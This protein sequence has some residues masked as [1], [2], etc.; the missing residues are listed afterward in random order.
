MMLS[1]WWGQF[2]T[3]PK[4]TC[5]G[6][7][8]AVM[9]VVRVVLV[10]LGGEQFSSLMVLLYSSLISKPCVG[11]GVP[12]GLGVPSECVGL[13]VPNEWLELSGP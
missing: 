5:T 6:L 12:N 2:S 10:S 3:S 11:F 1:L 13:G 8:A 4:P 7:R 9:T